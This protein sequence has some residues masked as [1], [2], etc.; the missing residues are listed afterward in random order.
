MRVG[1]VIYGS[2]ETRSGGYLYDRKLVEFLRSQGDE[3]I[4][5]SL[6]WRNYPRHLLQNLDGNRARAIASARPDILIQDELNHP[7]LFWLNPRLKQEAR[8]PIVSLVHHLRSEEAHPP[9][10][11]PLYRAVEARYLRSV[12]GFICNSR[13]TRASVQAL[14][15]GDRPSVIAYPGREAQLPALSDEAIQARARETGPL[16]LLFVGNLIPR[17]GLHTL[18]EAL[19]HLPPDMARLTVVGDAQADARYSRR[20]REQALRLGLDARVR[21]LGAIPDDALRRVYATHH[22]LVVPSQH[23]GFGIVY[24]EA[25]GYGLIAVGTEAGGAGEIIRPGETGLLIPPG[26]AEALATRLLWL[27]QHRPE[28]SH[29]GIAARRAWLEHPT[30]EDSGKRIRA[31]LMEMTHASLR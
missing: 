10:L 24:L 3:V 14:A 31:F 30:W 12:D 20:V 4:L 25:M 1:F 22:A 6:P 16:R 15:E 17:K 19:A 18:L 21:W 27:H 2:L 11:L 23:E 5:F 26:D 7:S 13:A 8:F 28:M 29:M 9:A